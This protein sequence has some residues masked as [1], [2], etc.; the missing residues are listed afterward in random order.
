[1]DLNLIYFLFL[2]PLAIVGISCSYTDIKYGKIFNKWIILGFIY[3]FCLYIFIFFFLEGRV[4]IFKLILNG[5]IA[6][7][8]GYLLWYF[9]LWSAGDAKLFSVYAF[10]VPLDFYSKSYV[11]HFPSFNLL[12]NLFVPLLLVLIISAL[13]VTLKELYKAKDRIKKLKLPETKRVFQLLSYLF[14]L[15]LNY[16]FVFIILQ[17]IILPL[18][19][20]FPISEVFNN[21]FF[22][23]ALLLLTIVSFNKKRREKKWLNWVLYGVILAYICSIIFS[24]E[25]FDRLINLLRV[26]LVFMVFVGLTRNILN[27]YVQKR[28]IEKVKIKNIKEGMI[29]TKDE[30]SMFL[31]KI[32]EDFGALDAGGLSKNQVKLIKEFFKNSEEL[33]IKIYKTL[34]FAPFLFLSAI[35]SVFTQSSFLVLIDKAFRY[36]L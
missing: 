22:I 19:K 9:K 25:F 23:F 3:I 16:V 34:P 10:L 21:P 14:Q 6:F 32:K 26:S 36:F 18:T 27:L 30:S 4:Y 24:G 11:L 29:L 15:F 13:I 8:T 33:E 17:S 5:T 31:N 12:M 1:M 20:H 7:S 2:L 35:I 28:E